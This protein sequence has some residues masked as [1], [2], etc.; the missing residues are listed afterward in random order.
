MPNPHINT[1]LTL[2]SRNQRTHHIK[3]TLQPHIG[4]KMQDLNRPKHQA[5]LLLIQRKH[6]TAVWLKPKWE[7]QNYRKRNKTE[8]YQPTHLLTSSLEIP[9][10]SYSM[11]PVQ[12]LAKADSRLR[13]NNGYWTRGS[14][15][16]RKW[17][18]E[19]EDMK[20]DEL[21]YEHA[22]R[23]KDEENGDGEEI[24]LHNC[25]DWDEMERTQEWRCRL[26]SGAVASLVVGSKV[27]G[28]CQMASCGTG[29]CRTAWLGTCLAFK[30]M[31]RHHSAA[32]PYHGYFIL[33]DF[34][35][36]N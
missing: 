25:G 32:Y 5:P 34:G 3:N 35:L 15:N 8:P 22:C 26:G 20:W 31:S 2:E 13:C 7:D 4:N 12:T 17:R 29:T 6:K 30:A 19:D 36:N 10:F 28:T 33:L 27:V 18:D 16:C 9:D 14:N 24:S 11:T 23:H 1:W 21:C